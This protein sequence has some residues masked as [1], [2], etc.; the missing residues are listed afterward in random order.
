MG[1]VSIVATSDL[2]GVLPDLSEYQGDILCI[3]GDIVPLGIQRSVIDSFVWLNDKFFPWLQKLKQFKDIFFIAGNHD[4]VFDKNFR[5]F[6]ANFET[7]WSSFLD[8][9]KL[10]SSP[11]IHYLE[12]SFYI[13]E[14]G[15][16]VYGC[17]NVI[18]PAG[19][20]FYLKEEKYKEVLDNILKGTNI[21]LCHQP[22]MIQDI[23]KV[24][25]DVEWSPNYNVDYGSKA[26]TNAI[27]DLNPNLVLCGH[28]HGGSHVPLSIGDTTIV[29]VSYKD[30]EYEDYKDVAFIGD[31]KD[32]WLGVWKGE[33]EV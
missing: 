1:K 20:A 15:I 8:K 21:L 7:L 23:G 33:I 12:N 11:N 9:L 31:E 13:L 27:T 24:I 5:Y 30:E 18:G 32:E 19:W 3:C 28:I 4:F 17:P 10:Y 22:P 26:L 14:N 16:S 2:H 25:D 29:N 6:S